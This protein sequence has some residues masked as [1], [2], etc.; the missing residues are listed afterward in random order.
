MVGWRLQ[1]AIDCIQAN[2][3]GDLPLS[4]LAAAAGFSPSHF[5]RAFKAAVGEPPHRY[6]IRLRIERARHLL[7]HTRLPIIEVG[8]QCGFEQTTHFATMFRKVTGLSPRAYRAAR[9][10]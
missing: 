3:A 2:L 5:A 7:E 10:S 1:K 4:Q 6:M 9:R 8:Y